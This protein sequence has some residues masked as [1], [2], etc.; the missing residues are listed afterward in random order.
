MSG[1]F[2]RLRYDQPAY[3]E[4]VERSVNPMLYRLDPNYAVNCNQ[5]FAPYGPRNGHEVSDAVGQ[6]I[7]VDSI[8]R[9]VSQINT[10]SNVQQQPDSL[11]GYQLRALNNCSDLLEPT[12]SRYQT[13][14]YEIRGMTVPDLH[15]SYPIQ[16]PQCQ[17][18]ENF[19]TNTRLQAK[20]NHRAVWQLPM[21]D[22]MICEKMPAYPTE[23]L[24]PVKNFSNRNSNYA[25]FPLK[26]YSA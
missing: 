23:R 7:D 13:P 14:A 15:L 11:T 4:E 16:D 8:L 19:E 12:Y 18:F 26:S 24:G 9:G 20:D 21:R 10:K 22:G 3:N 1:T 17:I 5:C 6:Q 2:N 25:P